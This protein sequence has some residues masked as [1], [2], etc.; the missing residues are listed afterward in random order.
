MM[1][2]MSGFEVLEALG[3]DASLAGLPVVVLTARGSEADARHGLSL[4]ARRYMSKPFAVEELIAEVRKHVGSSAPQG[5]R[6][7]L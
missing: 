2:D 7:S 4:G 6:A 5:R 1:P 3:R